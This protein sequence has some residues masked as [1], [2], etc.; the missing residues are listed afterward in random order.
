MIALTGAFM[1]VQSAQALPGSVRVTTAKLDGEKQVHVEP[2]HVPGRG[3][4]AVLMIGGFWSSKAPT[5]FTLEVVYGGAKNII[6]MKLNIDGTIEELKPTESSTKTEVPY[7]TVV[8]TRRFVVS[9]D[10]LERMVAA[11]KCIVQVSLDGEF[12]EGEFHGGGPTTCRPALRKALVKIAE[13]SGQAPK[14]DEKAKKSKGK[15]DT[16]GRPV[17]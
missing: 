9:L 1:L 8:S 2:G 14:Q 5:E 7:G 6:G 11:E 12:V 13:A 16:L 4:K 17:K 15:T 3:L 10:F